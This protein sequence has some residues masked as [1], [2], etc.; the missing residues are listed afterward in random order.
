MNENRPKGNQKHIDLSGRIRI[1][2]GLNNGESFRTIARDLNKDPSTISKEVRRHSVIKE[3]KP[4]AF[5]PIPCANNYD[6]SK[7][8]ANVCKI[9]HG[10]GDNECTHKCV[11]C[12]KARCSE[13]CNHYKPRPVSYTH[14]D[15]YK[16][17]T[18]MC[19]IRGKDMRKSIRVRFRHILIRLQ[20]M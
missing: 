20:V 10:C 19:S 3:R 11:N 5:A 15:V 13:I 14:L 8:K 16:R 2:Q 9:L 1:E 17:Q 18:Q 6:A 7:P 4:N 12:R